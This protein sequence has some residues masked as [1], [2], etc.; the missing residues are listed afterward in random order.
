MGV[1]SLYSELNKAFIWQSQVLLKIP[2]FIM[3]QCSKE[4]KFMKNFTVT[5]I[6]A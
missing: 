5:V 6:K 3:T 1:L 2:H 4:Y